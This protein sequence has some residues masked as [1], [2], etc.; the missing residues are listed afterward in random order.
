MELREARQ[1]FAGLLE[2]GEQTIGADG[3]LTNKLLTPILNSENARSPGLNAVG[4]GDEVKMM[5]ILKAF[6]IDGQDQGREGHIRFSLGVEGDFHRMAVDAFKHRDGGFTLISVD[7]MQ[8]HMGAYEMG[9]LRKR[10]PDIIKGTMHIPTQNL[11]HSEGCRIFSVLMLNAMHDY[12]P[13][14]QHL[15]RQIHNA[16]RGRPAPY[17]ADPRWEQQGGSHLPKDEGAAFSV[18]P[19]KFFKHMQVKKPNKGITTTA[20]DDAEKMNPALKVQP[21]NK[22]GQTLRQR[23]ESLNPSRRPEEFS[24]ADRTSSVDNKR[25]VLIDRALA[26]HDSH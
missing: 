26:Y 13:Y 5:T 3:E 23:F 2:R 20:L 18:L 22:K 11:V 21:V 7:S 24:R 25:L 14:F 19:G 8:N 17:L 6:S 16:A 10:Y 4:C 1:H 12:E 9:A 15:H